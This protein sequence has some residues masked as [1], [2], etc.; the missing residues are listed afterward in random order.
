MGGR[1][2]G[3]RPTSRCA[4][5]RRICHGVAGIGH[6]IVCFLAIVLKG[7]AN[8]RGRRKMS[9]PKNRRG[10]KGGGG[11]GGKKRKEKRKED[12]VEEERIVI[13]MMG[14]LVD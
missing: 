12:E 2:Y 9:V 11:G 10:E 14:E 7:V 3:R 8:W 13:E 6:P 5:C 4:R 1:V